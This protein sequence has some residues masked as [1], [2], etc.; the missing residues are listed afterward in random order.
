MSNKENKKVSTS[1]HSTGVAKAGKRSGTQKHST[2][3]KSNVV[4]GYLMDKE[5]HQLSAAY[6]AP[7]AIKEIEIKIANTRQYLRTWAQ[8]IPAWQGIEFMNIMMGKDLPDN[9]TAHRL[10]FYA[11]KLEGLNRLTHALKVQQDLLDNS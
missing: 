6:N 5:S 7:I 4:E 10:A 2:A 1:G 8:T 9:M 3:A 11:R